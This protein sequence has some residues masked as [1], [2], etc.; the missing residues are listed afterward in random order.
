MKRHIFLVGLWFGSSKPNIAAFLD[1]FTSE[2][3]RLGSV[4][5]KWLRDGV[6]VCSKVF[7]C[8]C[9]CDSVARALLQNIHQFNG[10]YGCSCCYNPGVRI[11]K[12][13]GHARVYL[14]S[15]E[16]HNLRTHEEINHD[17]MMAFR[18]QE[19][20]NGVKGPS[21]LLE[22]PF[23][24]TVRGFPVDNLHCVD[25]GVSRQ[26]GHLWFDSCFHQE[27]WYLGRRIQS[28]MLSS[29]KLRL[30]MRSPGSLA[31]L[32]KEHSGKALNGIG[33]FFFIAQLSFM[34]CCL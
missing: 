13:Q 27:L 30:P 26:L 34:E 32:R 29:N 33:G 5:M 25:L 7:A 15:S 20:V 9:S 4:G 18:Q 24:N 12:G 19:I 8:I 3:R 14:P 17:A 31:H 11:Q 6:E 1:P 23:F 21:K 10:I 22:L 2:M 16:G 28:S